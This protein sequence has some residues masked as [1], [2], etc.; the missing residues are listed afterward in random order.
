MLPIEIDGI[1]CTHNRRLW[2]WKAKVYT[3]HRTICLA[4]MEG[5]ILYSRKRDA[6]HRGKEILKKMFQGLGDLK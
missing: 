6:I 2:I 3:P 1:R 4:N 5:T